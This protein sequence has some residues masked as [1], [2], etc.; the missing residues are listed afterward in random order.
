MKVYFHLNLNGFSNCYLV[1][2]EETSEAIIIDPGK[3]TEEIISQI[4]DNHLKLVAVLITHNHGSHVS[5]LKTLRKIYSP[6]IFAADW[7]VAG[8]ETTVISGDGKTRLAKMQVRYMALPGHTAD[9]VVYGIGNL[10][11]TGDV[12]SAG[13]VGSTNSSYSEYILRSNIE[14]KIY[15]QLDDVIIMPGHGPPST[16]EAIK[17]FNTELKPL[18]PEKITPLL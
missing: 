9:S 18:D 6:K 3:I 7:E 1:V 2:N 17:A 16:L 13:E 4:E 5:G 15:S 11:F 8:N 10:L 14:Q 12:L